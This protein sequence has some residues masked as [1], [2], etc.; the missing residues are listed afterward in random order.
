ML[1]LRRTLVVLV[2]FGAG[3]AGTAPP[4]WAT[5]AEF[6]I[7]PL[8]L[9]QAFVDGDTEKFR[10]HHWMN[11]GY[12]GGIKEFMGRAV[13][14]DGTEI[15]TGGHALIDANDLGAEFSVKK[16]ALGFLTFDYDEFR[17]YF[18]GT[19][20]VHRR[21]ATLQTSDTDKE[22]ALDIGKFGVETGLTLEGWP[23]LGFTYER[24]FKDGAKSRLS[25]TD[26]TEFGE[27]RKIGPSWQDIDEIVDS[28]ALTA[29]HELAGFSLKGEQRWEFVRSELFREERSL[30]TNS[31]AS[32][33]KIRRQDQ[34]PEA[35]LMTTLLEAERGFLKDTVFVASAYRFA[36]MDN[37]EFESLL[38]SNAS[39]VQTNFSNPKQ[40]INAR[41]DNDYDTHTWVGNVTM[42]PWNFL[43]VGTKLKSE[44]IKRESNSSYPTDAVPNSTGGSTP[45]GVI[46]RTDVSLN[47]TKAVRWGEALTVRFTGIPRT[48]LYTE[49]E[50]E[51]ARVL[52]RE[53]RKSL[54]GPDAGD[55]S[56]AGE[57]F[58]RE[59]VTDVRRGAWTLGGR[60]APMAALDLTA[61]VRRRV[62]NS[63]YDDQR[64][65][66]AAGGALSAFIDMQN[67]H[68]NE[69]ATRATY[70][71]CRWFRSSVRYQL[72]QDDYSTR[73]EAQDTVEAEMRSNIYTYD[74]VLQ[75]H[76]TLTTTASFSRQTAVTSTPARLA[77]TANIPAFHADVNTWL[78]GAD[79]SPKPNVTWTNAL[80]LS[81]ADNFNDYANTG[82]PYGAA[83]QRT[84]FTT[85]VTWALTDTAS[86]G[87][88]YA[89]F[90][91]NPNENIESGDYGA[92]VIWLELSAKF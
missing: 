66:V 29:D 47:N 68:T 27:T 24:E 42:S 19:G 88:D 8:P 90:T 59:T 77:S 74:V 34:A 72:K 71:P 22:L 92:H 86:V 43:S 40:Q 53:D 76:R 35:N 17:K 61:H 39:G 63:D 60:F 13:L 54:D 46:D 64:E 2:A 62:N 81:W 10:A 85:G 78:V 5:E 79:Y 16:E 84:D 48:A 49:L 32:E 11:D 7:T 14:P 70:R 23:E 75:P 36:H 28:F 69:F 44:V 33:R 37:R 18:D 6:S 15:A 80:Q 73:F 3:V 58:N 56:S 87:A 31:T 30:S 21:F 82:L 55:G 51:Q 50:L 45:N 57:V 89:F 52:L 91:Y 83:F 25:W 12:A 26:V 38:E 20:G 1:A 4:A 9:R 67:V 65:S 41:A